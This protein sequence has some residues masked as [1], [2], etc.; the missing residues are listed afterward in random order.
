MLVS[1]QE[2]RRGQ[3]VFGKEAGPRML[4]KPGLT[5]P[6]QNHSTRVSQGGGNDLVGESPLLQGVTSTAGGSP[7]SANS[8]DSTR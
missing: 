1:R 8:F 4:R 6:A 2:A 5:P 3:A 7:A